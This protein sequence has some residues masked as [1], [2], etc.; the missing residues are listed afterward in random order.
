MPSE[1]NK[2]MSTCMAQ[3]NSTQTATCSLRST[4]TIKKEMVVLCVCVCGGGG[5]LSG[6]GFGRDCGK[7]ALTRGLLTI[8]RSPPPPP[9]KHHFGKG[10]VCVCVC[11]GGGGGLCEGSRAVSSFVFFTV[12]TR[13]I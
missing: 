1:L 3:F 7:R 2:L 11:G 9:P 8:I 6:E 10:D 5:G 4:K 13:R 12:F